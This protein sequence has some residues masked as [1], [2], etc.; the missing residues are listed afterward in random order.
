MITK[1]LDGG[2]FD[3]IKAIRAHKISE[4]GG[5]TEVSIKNLTKEELMGITR[6]YYLGLQEATDKLQV[7]VDKLEQKINFN[8]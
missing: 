5:F 6:T 4:G 1:I 3:D 2:K 7:F 8:K